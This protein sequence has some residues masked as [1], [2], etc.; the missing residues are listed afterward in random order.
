MEKLG[1]STTPAAT[2]HRRRHTPV[3]VGAGLPRRPA[4]LGSFLDGRL[5]RIL[6][7][8][9]RLVAAR[10]CASCRGHGRVHGRPGKGARHR[11]VSDLQTFVASLDSMFGGFR[12]RAEHTKPCS[13]RPRPLRRRCGPRRRRPAGGVLLRRAARGRRD[14]PR[15]SGAQ[16]GAHSAA[17]SLDAAESL[18][19]AQRLDGDKEHALARGLLQLHADRM[20]VV[21]T[22]TRLVDRFAASH[23][24]V[25]RASVP[26][27]TADVHDLDGLRQVGAALGSA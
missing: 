18:A 14:A 11:P 4:R 9:P 13:A 1:H 16:P 23:P 3:A 26:A 17:T 5:V 15:R 7:A 12:E 19:G 10:T 8:P 6:T 2:N 25:R 20:T 21:T 27:F 24:R 22:E